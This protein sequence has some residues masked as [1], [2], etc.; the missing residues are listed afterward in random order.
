MRIFL[1]AT[2]V[3][4]AIA[5]CSSNR[6]SVDSNEPP[7][8]RDGQGNG[9]QTP[10]IEN[11]SMSPGFSQAQAAVRDYAAKFYS[12]KPDAISVTPNHEGT[13]NLPHMGRIGR[14]WRFNAQAGDDTITVFAAPDGTVVSHQQN[15]GLLFEE[16]GVWT[17]SPKLN[18]DELAK[19][20]VGSM[21]MEYRVYDDSVPPPELTLDAS[22]AGTL[23]F[24]VGRKQRGPGGAGG[25]PEFKSEAKVVLT[26]DRQGTL[27]LT[28][29]HNP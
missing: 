19:R 17:D 11:N 21:G 2:L 29:W 3:L 15:L 6:Q 9:S 13:A 7:Q 10:P 5:G 26:P 1:L 8:A 14:L 27:E 18:A 25:G 4:G 28:E 20:I 23:V 12:I 22:G 16:A 24:H